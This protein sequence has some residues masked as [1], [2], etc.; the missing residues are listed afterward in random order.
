MAIALAAIE[1]AAQLSEDPQE[2]GSRLLWAAAMADEQGDAESVRRLL[3]VVD[4]AQLRRADWFR[5]S[6]YRE[7]WGG[8]W[9]GSARLGVYT[10]LIDAMRQADDVELTLDSLVNICLRFYW[11]NPDD[12]TRMRFVEVA[13][14]V[15]AP[16]TTCECSAR[17]PRPRPS[18]AART[19][20]TG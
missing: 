20:S 4:E 19:A 16:M 8:G 12:R 2:R 13:E 11:S 7:L 10:E 15:D 5:L 17:W 6:W 14:L 1:R 18:N 9:T 3:G